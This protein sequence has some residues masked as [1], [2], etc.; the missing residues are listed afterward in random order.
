MRLIGNQNSLRTCVRPTEDVRVL[1]L[2]KQL[3]CSEYGFKHNLRQ[4]KLFVYLRSA[5]C[6]IVLNMNWKRDLRI[7]MK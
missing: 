7:V 5:D 2:E 4:I 1:T 3:T 6:L